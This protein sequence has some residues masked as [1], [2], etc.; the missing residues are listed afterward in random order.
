MTGIQRAIKKLSIILLILSLFFIISWPELRPKEDSCYNGKLDFGEDEIDCGGI[1]S[2]AC[3]PPEKPPMVEDV[4]IEWS[5]ALKD[6]NDNYDLIAK[7][8]NTNKHW[9]ATNVNYKFIIYGGNNDVL[10]IKTGSTYI[11]PLGFSEGEGVKYVI[12]NNYVSDK[13]ITKVDFELDNFRWAE[14]KDILELPE[15]GVDT[16]IVKDRRYGKVE[17]GNEYYYIYGVTENTSK[18]SFRFVDI[19]AV[20]YDAQNN[21]IAAGKT[22]QN[23]VAAGTGWEFRIFWNDK[24]EGEV[25]KV[26]YVAETNIYEQSNFMRA[27][28]TGKKYNTTK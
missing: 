23:T 4:K 21:P 12:E 5:R 6:G 27:Y 22:D 3:P 24:F 15:L 25:A 20:V 9:G 7:I 28:G 1:C 16:I 26:D 18:Y 13:E 2:T 10:A 8:Y 14:V 19:Y 17:S 11:V